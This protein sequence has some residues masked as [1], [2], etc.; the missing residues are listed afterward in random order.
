MKAFAVK[1]NAKVNS[2]QTCDGGDVK[3]SCREKHCQILWQ[4]KRGSVEAFAAKCNAKVNSQQICD[5]GGVKVSCSE[6][7]CHIS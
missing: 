4:K 6:K 2:R 5:G 7:H 3:L 1:S